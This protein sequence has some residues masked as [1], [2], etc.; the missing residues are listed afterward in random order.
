M[1]TLLYV[2]TIFCRHPR[3]ST[4]TT[5]VTTAFT[6]GYS[7][8]TAFAV[9]TFT[10]EHGVC[11]EAVAASTWIQLGVPL[12][13]FL[14]LGTS[15]PFGKRR[16]MDPDASRTGGRMRT[17]RLCGKGRRGGGHHRR[18]HRRGCAQDELGFIQNNKLN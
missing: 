17:L 16:P 6:H 12:W 11:T 14:R 3:H 18:L 2:N 9:T 10:H 13:Y 8:S 5:F 15:R 4:F 1:S 7:A